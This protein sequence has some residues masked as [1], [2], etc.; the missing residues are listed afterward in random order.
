MDATL[1]TVM[2]NSYPPQPKQK[3]F[4][5]Q[6]NLSRKLDVRTTSQ[7]EEQK[8][9]ER[10]WLAD[11]QGEEVEDKRRPQHAIEVDVE[12]NIINNSD[13]ATQSYPVKPCSKH[14]STTPHRMRRKP[15][16]NVATAGVPSPSPHGD[17]STNTVPSSPSRASI[18]SETAVEELCN[19]RNYY[20]KQLKRINYVSHEYLGQPTEPGVLACIRE[21]LRSLR[22][23]HRETIAQM[24][25]SL[26]TRVSG[27]NKLV[28]R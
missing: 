27:R 17:I 2:D 22:L 8:E 10:K 4:K 1:P 13:D 20:S 28:H 18:I 21:P 25:R 6:R 3:I 9:R 24:A 11:R 23:P 15:C 26:W 14:K 12:I 16:A 7:T 19:L 5:Q